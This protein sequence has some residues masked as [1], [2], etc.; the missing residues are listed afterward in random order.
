MIKKASEEAL[1]ISLRYFNPLGAHS[2]LVIYENPMTE[3]GN[4][5]PKPKV[6]LGIENDFQ[7]L[8]MIT[9]LEMEQVKEITYIYL[10]Y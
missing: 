4:I 6:F 1:A 5:M 10:I 9:T 2:D 7:Y 3:F 8:A